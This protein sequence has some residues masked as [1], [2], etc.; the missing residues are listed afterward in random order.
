MPPSGPAASLV[1]AALPS[2]EWTPSFQNP[3]RPIEDRVIDEFAV[4]LYR[5]AARRFRLSE[6]RDHSLGIGNLRLAGREDLVDDPDLLRVDAHL[7]LEAEAEAEGGAGGH[8]EPL[9]VSEI[10]PN[11][12]EGGL[13]P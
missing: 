2:R 6:R 1:I 13:D 5:G 10:D 12:V 8:F 3:S 4:E 9:L 11:R 7:S